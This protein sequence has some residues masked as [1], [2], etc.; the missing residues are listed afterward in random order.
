MR[1][2]SVYLN[3]FDSR[4][5]TTFSHMSR[6]TWIGSGSGGQSTTSS[7]P[8]R[9][10]A[11]RKVL[12][13]SGVSAARS[14]GSNDAST[15]PASIRENSRSGVDQFQQSDAVPV[16]ELDPFAIV[17]LGRAVGEQ[18]LH[19]SEDQRQRRAE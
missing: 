1:P 7:M 14:V 15:R 6:S 4:F 8:A 18:V 16:N 5:R 3:A 17:R 2:C 11:E 12:A 13:R 19:R 9:S 10:T